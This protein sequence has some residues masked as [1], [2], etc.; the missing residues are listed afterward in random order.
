MASKDVYDDP[1]FPQQE[2]R[3]V[4]TPLLVLLFAGLAL[5]ILFVVAL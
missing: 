5:V 1:V 4:P 2:L 3:T